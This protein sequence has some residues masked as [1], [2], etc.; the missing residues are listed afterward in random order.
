MPIL[1]PPDRIGVLSH[2]VKESLGRHGK[3]GILPRLNPAVEHRGVGESL[4]L[5]S[6]RLTDGRCV[7][8]SASIE[9]DLE[10]AGQRCLSSFELAK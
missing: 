3:S 4:S 5:G 10:I 6:G 2:V 8:R 7:L 1:S 9:D